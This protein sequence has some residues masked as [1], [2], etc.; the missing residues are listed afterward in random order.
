MKKILI[1]DDDPK[2]LAALTRR[3]EANQYEVLAAGNGF[4][5]MKLILEEKPDLLLLDIWMPVGLGFSVAERLR[6]CRLNIPV[7]FLTASRAPGLTD[8]ARNVGAAAFVEKPYDPEHLLRLIDKVLQPG[9][10]A[11]AE[12]CPDPQPA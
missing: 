8:V 1:A 7:I 2:I 9:N 5:A 12:S 4:E 11:M 6:E 3:L 10:P